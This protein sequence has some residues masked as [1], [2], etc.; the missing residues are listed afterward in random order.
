MSETK[1]KI[2]VPT[3][4]SD[5]SLIAAEQAANLA[6]HVSDSELVLLHVIEDRGFLAKFFSLEQHEDVKKEVQKTLDTKAERIKKA[7]K[8]EVST[9]I[10]RG[11][12]YDKIAEVADLISASMI[13][14]GSQEGDGIKGRIIGSNALNV[15]KA[16]PLPVITVRGKKHRDG[17]KNIVLPLDLTKETKEKVS[18]AIWFARKYENA[19]I[20]V[21]SV[22]FTTD[23]F[24]VNRLTRQIGQVKTFVEKAGI[25]CTAEIIKG[26]KG[27]ESLARVI[28]DYSEK[29][30]GDIII[31][32]TQQEVEHT[33]YFI[34][35]S[36]Q[37]IIVNS[38]IPVMSVTPM[39]RKDTSVFHPY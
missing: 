38:D 33:P 17:C 16:S 30:E 35:S 3:D 13:V 20:R 9:L 23:E 34:G 18:N 8:I 37:E 6:S 11:A 2:L 25:N 28:I 10:A 7:H 5:Q 32:M 19:V 29:V 24:V 12:P 21:V 14:M 15:V 22:L 26:I 36:A 4:F 31:I 39:V 1:F 27:E